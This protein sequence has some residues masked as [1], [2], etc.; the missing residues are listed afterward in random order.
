MDARQKRLIIMYHEIQRL[1][2]VEHFSIQRIADKLK[3]N[4]RT[5]RK[6]L[7]MTE[8]DYDKFIEKKWAKGRL[9]DPYRD[10]IISYLQQYPDTPSAVMHDR[11]KERFDTLPRVDP[12]TVYNYVMTVRRDH[13]IHMVSSSERQYSAVPDLPAGHLAQVDF[14]EKKLRRS[15]GEWVKVYFFVIV[16]CYSRHKF[17]LFLDRPFT[18]D[19]AVIAHEKA[20][21]FFGGIPREIIYDQDSV[22]LHREN[23]GDY[24]MTDVFHRYQASRGFKVTFCRAGDPESKGKVEN[25]VKFVK[26]NF[27]FN[28]TFIN[29]NIL[30]DQVLAWLERTGNGTLHNTTRKV[31]QEQWLLERPF[32]RR[33]IP[34]LT[35]ARTNGHK[36]IKTNTIKYRGNSYSLPFGTYRNDESRVF[37]TEEGNELVIKNAAGSIITTHLIPDGVGHN[38]INTNHRRDTS[39]KLDVLRGKVREFFGHSGE[40]DTFIDKINKLYPRYVRDQLTAVLTAA[41]RSGQQHAGIALEFCVRNSLFSASDFKSVLQGQKAGR[42]HLSTVAR[43][44]IKPLGDARTQLIVNIEPERSDIREYEVI[45]NQSL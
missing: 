43:P 6:I 31:P 41:E 44:V 5:V 14:G 2:N 37:V 28:R 9:L 26:H 32:L 39:I 19:D 40:I 30:N 25:S 10:F 20:F 12:K 4:F 11:L 22:F 36:V 3:I 27:L 18:S 29:H 17:V 33:W 35:A 8:E 42:T 23:G 24:L 21:E 15:T 13:N 38:I 1:R 34:L 45:F 16:L 7:H